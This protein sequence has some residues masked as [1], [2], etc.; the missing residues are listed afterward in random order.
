MLRSISHTNS[1]YAAGSVK[2]MFSPPSTIV[3]RPLDVGV[4][5]YR[6]DEFDIWK[7]VRQLSDG[8]ADVL[9][10][11]AEILAAMACD[12]HHAAI[13]ATGGTCP[14]THVGGS[15]PVHG[16]QQR[17]DD[18]VPRDVDRGRMRSRASDLR[19]RGVGAQCSAA[20]RL[21]TRRFSSSGQGASMFPVRKPA[22]T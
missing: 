4:Q 10:A 6:V 7:L 19:P 22:S 16:P 20:T 12:Q 14:A 5:V 9:K 8:M 3:H 1:W 18:G 11:L 13:T 21:A 15:F 17:V 2:W